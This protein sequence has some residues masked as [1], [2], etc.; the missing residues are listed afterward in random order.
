MAVGLTITPD[1]ADLRRL[2]NA[3]KQ[4]RRAGGDQ[5]RVLGR[6]GIYMTREARRRLRARKRD[7]GPTTFRLSKSLAMVVD[8]NSVT[9]GSNLVYARIQQLG[10]TVRPKRKYLALP[11]DATLRRRGVWPRDLPKDS[12]KFV[13]NARIRIGSHAWTGPALVRANDVRLPRQAASTIGGGTFLDSAGR[14]RAADGKF[15]RKGDVGGGRTLPAGE[16]LFALVKRVRIKGRPY[17]VFDTKAKAFLLQQ[18]EADIQRRLR[19]LGG[20]N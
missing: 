8:A 6:V 9:V 18:I 12:L 1:R 5:R 13:P 17:L 20:T 19:G 7:W 4:L 14:L 15:I 10:G 3:F 11:V 2:Q 16:V